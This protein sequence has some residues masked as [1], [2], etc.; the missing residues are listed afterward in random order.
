MEH[1][2]DGLLAADDA[3]MAGQLVRLLR[4]EHLRGSIAAHNRRVAPRHGWPEALLARDALYARAGAAVS[5][6]DGELA[7]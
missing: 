4:D 7:R 6:P 3:Q 1:G 2:R 5:I